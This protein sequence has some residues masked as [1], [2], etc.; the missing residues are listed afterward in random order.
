LL[1]VE[2]IQTA[3]KYIK[4]LSELLRLSYDDSNLLEEAIELSQKG[5]LDTHSASSHD[6]ITINKILGEQRILELI[7]Q[8]SNPDLSNPTLKVALEELAEKMA[9]GTK[10]ALIGEDLNDQNPVAANVIYGHTKGLQYPEIIHFLVC[11]LIVR[12]FNAVFENDPDEE[13]RDLTSDKDALINA[14]GDVILLRSTGYESKY[15]KELLEIWTIPKG[16]GGLG[17]IDPG[18]ETIMRQL[19]T[20]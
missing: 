5:N 7:K 16:K 4:V 20:E 6:A 14:M 17:W 11:H 10:Y 3:K 18:L 19:R 2:I 8:L 1:I 13:V 9:L 15:W 12:L